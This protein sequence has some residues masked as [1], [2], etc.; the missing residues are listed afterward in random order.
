M[1]PGSKTLNKALD[2]NDSDFIDFLRGCLTWDPE[3]R[4]SPEA[5]FTHRWIQ[6]GLLQL[7]GHKESNVPSTSL[8]STL[9]CVGANTYYATL[10]QEDPGVEYSARKKTR[11]RVEIMN[12]CLQNKSTSRKASAKRGK[13][14]LPVQ[15]KESLHEKIWTLK[16][17]LRQFV[18]KKATEESPSKRLYNKTLLLQ[19][20]SRNNGSL[21]ESDQ[22]CVLKNSAIS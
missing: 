18:T 12:G 16:E 3:K 5:A 8:L 11:P 2:C 22:R 4:M 13:K 15:S 17:R 1:T 6:K 20:Q 9:D 7:P 14:V 21:I 19:E 10:K